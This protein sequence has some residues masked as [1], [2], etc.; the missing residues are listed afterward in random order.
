MMASH[1]WL[2]QYSLDVL[3]IYISIYHCTRY[4]CT[5]VVYVCLYVYFYNWQQ[6]SDGEVAL[7]IQASLA[8]VL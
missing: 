1:R 7:I 2:Y 3:Y 4:T 5:K 8:V 6:V